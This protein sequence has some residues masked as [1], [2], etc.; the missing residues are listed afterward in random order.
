MSFW[1]WSTIAIF[2]GRLFK[3]FNKNAYDVMRNRIL[4]RLNHENKDLV[5]MMNEARAYS[6][7]L[8]DKL[9]FHCWDTLLKTFEVNPS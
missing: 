4:Y 1:F 2:C 7:S 9:F 6:S 3:R 5:L 8:Y